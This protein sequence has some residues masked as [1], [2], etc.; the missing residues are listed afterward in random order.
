MVEITE[1]DLDAIHDS[2][3]KIIRIDTL[4]GNGEKGLCYDVRCHQHR[5]TRLELGIA[6]LVGTGTIGG[7]IYG[8]IKL[9]GG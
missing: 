6:F 8:L 9:L 3:D 7:G 5:I 4:L 1:K 2:H